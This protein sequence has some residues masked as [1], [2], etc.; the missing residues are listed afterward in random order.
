MILELV[1]DFCT[2]G[3]SGIF[4]FLVWYISGV[5]VA[6]IINIMLNKLLL[7][8]DERGDNFYEDLEMIAFSYLSVVWM[9]AFLIFT[10]F[11]LV[12]FGSLERIYTQ[13]AKR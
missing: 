8:P 4:N 6:T 10:I 7:K 5:I 11:C 13:V 12:F 1:K 9:G 3:F 2:W